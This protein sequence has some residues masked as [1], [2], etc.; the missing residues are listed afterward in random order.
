MFV[1]SFLNLNVSL[2]QRLFL[3]RSSLIQN[4]RLSAKLLKASSIRSFASSDQIISKLT[5]PNPIDSKLIRKTSNLSTSPFPF[6]NV[7]G[8]PRS[9]INLQNSYGLILN[10]L[11]ASQSESTSTK[12]GIKGLLKEYGPIAAGLYF[13]MSSCVFIVCLTSITFLGIDETKIRWAFER[14]KNFVGLQTK[15]EV[16]ANTWGFDLGGKWK[17]AAKVAK[18]KIDDRNSAKKTN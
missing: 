10:R 14:V 18:R 2:R 5:N 6:K 3:S 4:H 16:Q 8:V 7:L 13:F 12:R 15:S 11:Y 17:D 1:N 9:S